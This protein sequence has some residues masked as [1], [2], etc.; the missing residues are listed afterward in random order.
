MK[1]HLPVNLCRVVMGASLAVS[2]MSYA[3]SESLLWNGTSK[4]TW[5]VQGS[6][7]WLAADGYSSYEDGDTVIFRDKGTVGISSTVKPGSILVDIDKSLQFRSARKTD[8]CIAGEGELIK[9]GEGTLTIKSDNSHWAGTVWLK[10]GTIRTDDADALGQCSVIISGGAT[11][12]MSGKALHNDL[13]ISGKG[14]IKSG[15]KF[16][17]SLTLNGDLLKGSLVDIKYGQSV[18]LVSGSVKGKIT[19]EGETRVTGNCRAD[20]KIFTRILTIAENATLTVGSKGLNMDKGSAVSLSESSS[21]LLEGKFSAYSLHS[22]SAAIRTTSHKSSPVTFKGNVN[23]TSGSSMMVNG[24]LAAAS[25]SLTEGSSLSVQNVS[26]RSVKLKGNLSL[27]DSDM[28]VYGKLNAAN[29][30]MY[31]NAEAEHD[32]VLSLMGSRPQSITLKEDA[33]LTG[34]TLN[35]LGKLKAVDL[36]LTTSELLMGMARNQNVTLKGT[37]ELDH[38]TML[39]YG[40][41][42][43]ENLHLTD[44]TLTVNGPSPQQLSIKETASLKSTG[45]LT[46]IDLMGKFSSKN[47]ILNEGT[48]LNVYGLRAQNVTVSKSLTIGS[49]ASLTLNGKLQAGDMLMRENASLILNGTKFK[50]ITIRG[51]LTIEGDCKI[52]LSA[53]DFAENKSYKLLTFDSC[54]GVDA[55]DLNALFGVTEGSG[56]MLTMSANAITLKLAAGANWNPYFETDNEGSEE[57]PGETVEGGV[58]ETPAAVAALVNPVLPDYSGVAD[59]LVQANWGLVE[60]SRA[61]VNTIANRSMAVQLGS[62]ERAVWASAIAGTSRRSSSGTHGGAD[63]NITGGAIGMETQLGE[64]SLLGMA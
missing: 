54:S 15:R 48:H 5:S 61:F 4:D 43:A 3:E 46:R 45:T 24:N 36:S 64:N 8:G 57:T 38:S 56:C 2:V 19:G 44:S 27:I 63:T 7:F 33:K 58:I 31:A 12:N 32:T 26:P 35:L 41:M 60:S 50:T 42:K 28:V 6:A 39:V 30:I 14:I 22:T 23:L 29:L 20:G 9:L 1:L 37:A 62:G 25:L 51:N 53:F 16:A 47:L 21:L 49:Y 34:S 40:R 17:G 18:S 13:T 55:D 52:D 10:N 11:L 59:A